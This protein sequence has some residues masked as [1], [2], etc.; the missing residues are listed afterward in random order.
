MENA[1][2]FQ[3]IAA[4]M[5]EVSAIGKDKQN[6][7]QGFKFR[8]IDDVYNALHPLLAKHKV[9]TVPEVLTKESTFETSQSGNKLFYERLMVRYTFFAD[10]GSS[11]QATVY[12]I[13]MDSGDKAANKAMAI[14]HKYVLLQVFAIPTEDM[15]DPDADTPPPS[16]DPMDQRRPENRP[17]TTPT[18]EHKVANPVIRPSQ[19]TNVAPRS[20]LA[21]RPPAARP[22]TRPASQPPAAPAA[23]APVP[24][25]AQVNHGLRTGAQ[26]AADVG[27]ITAEQ[28][29]MVQ[30]AVVVAK[31]PLKKWKPWFK[32]VYGYESIAEIKKGQMAGIMTIIKTKPEIILN[33]GTDPMVV[34]TPPLPAQP[35][36]PWE[37]GPRQAGQDDEEPLPTPPEGE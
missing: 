13:G 3:A 14:A 32:A 28:F 33:Y 12:G 37:E 7:K 18:I 15:V 8:G 31:I 34:Q 27:V 22:A 35:P 26:V 25:T 23:P 9:F 4:I 21:A 6:V 5:E 2:I 30:S 17:S 29:D 10:D 11:F 36:L 20:Q 16:V 19:T 1:K 24:T